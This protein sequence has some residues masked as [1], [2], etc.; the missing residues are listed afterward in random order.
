MGGII[1]GARV[2][3]CS[4]QRLISG[5]GGMALKV[6]FVCTSCGSEF[7]E[8]YTRDECM[9]CGGQIRTIDGEL[10]DLPAEEA[11]DEHP[12]DDLEGDESLLAAFD[13]PN[14][15]LRKLFERPEYGLV[16]SAAP[17]L[18]REVSPDPSE[19]LLAALRVKHGA[20]RRGYLLATS[21][22]L[23]W[24]Q[25]LPVKLNEY[26]PY[27]YSLELDG[28]YI[29]GGMIR[30]ASGDQFQVRYG[31]AKSFVE[32]YQI[33]QQAI[34][35]EESQPVQ[36]PADTI[37]PAKESDLSSQ[38]SALAS[39]HAAGAL[40]DVEFTTAKARLLGL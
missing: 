37:P 34:A 14:P 3:I 11:E 33:A 1:C 4:A 15:W 36:A 19:K 12:D 40:T 26:W 17:H 5:R 22:C 23:R 2:R 13:T 16:P 30:T 28:A 9:D 27:D 35:W 39:L 18:L 24:V 20:Y 7:T 31:K 10:I 32:V 21:L 8:I 29:S 6:A 38:L 25:T